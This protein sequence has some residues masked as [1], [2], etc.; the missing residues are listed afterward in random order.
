MN[1]TELVN[2]IR[3]KRSFLCVGLDTDPEKLPAHL[4]KDANGVLAFNKAIIES[5]LPYTVSYKLNIAFYEAMGLDGWKALQ[6]TIKLIPKGEAL[7]IADAKRGDIGNSASQYAKAF[8]DNLDCDAITVNPYMGRDS[9]EPF[10]S[11]KGKWTIALGLTSNIGAIDIELLDLAN[12]RMVFEEAI[13][14]LAKLGTTDNLMFVVGATKADYFDKIRAI[15]PEHFLLVPGVGA[16]GGKLEDLKGVMT[17]DC[18]LLVNSSRQ[19]IYADGSEGFAEKAAIQA[20]K[21][22]QQM[23]KML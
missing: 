3:R 20:E 11:Y 6:E 18:G 4:P 9:V 13:E 22:Q 10:L 15:I 19:I 7:I 5:T 23:A 1:K 21:I 8:F 2:L 12:G 17:N 14:S 16:Q